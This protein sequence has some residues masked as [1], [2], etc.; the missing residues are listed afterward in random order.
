V[1]K[2]ALRLV[3]LAEMLGLAGSGESA[4][5]KVEVRP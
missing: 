5:A 3:R 1:V 4:A 2:R